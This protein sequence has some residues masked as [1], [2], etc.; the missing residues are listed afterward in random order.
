MTP[1]VALTLAVAATELG[2][3]GH[4]DPDGGSALLEVAIGVAVGIA[5]GLGSAALLTLGSRRNWSWRGVDDSEPWVPPSAASP[6][7]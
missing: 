2:I 1:V 4:H 5:V 7:R 6:S 3:A